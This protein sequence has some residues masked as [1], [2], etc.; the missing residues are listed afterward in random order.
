MLTESYI[1]CIGSPDKPVAHSSYKDAGI[2][3]NQF[4]PT[5]GLT[6]T[7]K[8]SVTK[9]NCLAVTSTHIFTAQAG[10]AVVHIYSRA[11]GNQEALVPFADRLSSVALVGQLEGPGILVLGTE[12]GRVIL[13]EVCRPSSIH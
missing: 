9:P 12:S 5:A 6:A 13:W 4:Q 10:K 7:F 1:A 3:V 2:F 11:R 8:K